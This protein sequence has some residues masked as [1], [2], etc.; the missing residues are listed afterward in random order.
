MIL[1]MRIILRNFNSVINILLQASKG[2][3]TIIIAHRLSTIKHADCIVAVKDGKV[4]EMGT[5]DELMKLKKVYFQLVILQT[6]AE[7]SISVLSDTA[8]MLSESERG[9]L[10]L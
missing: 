2:R 3:T 9:K 4:V 1:S 10:S 7:D 6:L 8:S 5:H